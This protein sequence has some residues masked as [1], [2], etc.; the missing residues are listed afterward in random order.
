MPRFD[1]ARLRPALGM[2]EGEP[3]AV[4]VEEVVVGAP[5]RPRFV[6][7]GGPAI[8]LELQTARRAE[9]VHEAVAAV[10]VLRRIDHH[11][12]V[13]EDLLHHRV[14]LGREQVIRGLQGCIGRADHL[15]EKEVVALKRTGCGYI[16]M[17]VESGV[18]DRQATMKKLLT[19]TLALALIM[20]VVPLW[21][22]EEKSKNCPEAAARSATA[23]GT[24]LI[25]GEDASRWR[26]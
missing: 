1:E 15:T 18:Q 3:V 22:G 9:V 7:L 13:V 24:S 5:S 6:V 4:E 26:S 23:D 25:S 20:P 8:A 17:G 12:G 2:D 21:A 11:D 16:A 10:G 14:V 19:T